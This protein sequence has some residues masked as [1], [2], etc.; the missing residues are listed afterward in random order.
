MPIS[1]YEPGTVSKDRSLK[2][3]GL[4]VCGDNAGP[5]EL[6]L[7]STLAAPSPYFRAGDEERKVFV[8]SALMARIVNPSKSPRIS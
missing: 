7:A 2:K 3:L 5:T 8:R 1:R 4:L 6:G